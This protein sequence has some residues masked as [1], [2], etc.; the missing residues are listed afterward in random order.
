MENRKY[1]RYKSNAHFLIWG[2]GSRSWSVHLFASIILRSC[3][4]IL[5][6]KSYLKFRKS[7]TSEIFTWSSS[8]RWITCSRKTHLSYWR[9]KRRIKLKVLSIK[10]SCSLSL[11]ITAE[12]PLLKARLILIQWLLADANVYF[13]AQRIARRKMLNFTRT[14]VWVKLRRFKIG[15]RSRF[16]TTKIGFRK[17]LLN[18]TSSGSEKEGWQVYKTWRTLAI[19]TALFS[20]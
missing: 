17:A 18:R 3:W 19:W 1:S 8:L 2:K 9:W 14:N 15:S 16:K 20:A 7:S 5:K 11:A 12:S 13:T 4:R 6:M 10:P